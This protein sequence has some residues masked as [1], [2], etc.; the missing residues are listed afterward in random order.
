MRKD[1]DLV[2]ELTTRMCADIYTK[3]FVD[4]GKWESACELI[5]I[6][7]PSKLRKIVQQ[8]REEDAEAQSNEGGNS[9]VPVAR[10][11]SSSSSSGVSSSD[12]PSSRTRG[13]SRQSQ[14]NK[15]VKTPN[16]HVSRSDESTDDSASEGP[17]L[18][19]Q[20]IFGGAVGVDTRQRPLIDGLYKLS[21]G[22]LDSLRRKSLAVLESTGDGLCYIQESNDTSRLFEAIRDVIPKL[23][24]VNGQS[25]HWTFP[26]TSVCVFARDQD[27]PVIDSTGDVLAILMPN[28]S[29]VAF[30]TN[31]RVVSF[32]DPASVYNPEYALTLRTSPNTIKLVWALLL[33][34]TDSNDNIPQSFTAQ[35]AACACIQWPVPQ[36]HARSWRCASGFG[37]CL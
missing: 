10:G 1:F 11:E 22:D 23:V 2:Y 27:P 7:D 25:E 12:V 16:S 15:S 9:S 33:I 24:A 21:S 32:R 19:Y 34:Y 30:E 17:R 8:R 37:P 5:N 28:G 13:V 26:F 6:I 36:K 18:G 3:A 31:G 4:S 29:S 14:S 35:V 20:A